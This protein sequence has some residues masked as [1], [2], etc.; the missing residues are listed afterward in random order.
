MGLMT[1]PL[2]IGGAAQVRLVQTDPCHL[3]AAAS[4][5][6]WAPAAGAARRADQEGPGGASGLCTEDERD[7]RHAPLWGDEAGLCSGV[8]NRAVGSCAGRTGGWVCAHVWHAAH[9]LWG[10][11]WLLWA[12][13]LLCFVTNEVATRWSQLHLSFQC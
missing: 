12:F 13:S 5:E 1:L 8:P 11:P 7:R 6:A 10:L 4:L 3:P 2:A 9:I